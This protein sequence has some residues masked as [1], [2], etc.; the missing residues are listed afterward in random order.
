MTIVYSAN[1]EV[2]LRAPSPNMIQK[3]A[4][5][6][7]AD[8]YQ[9]VDLS[10]IDFR[11]SWITGKPKLIPVQ[12]SGSGNPSPFLDDEGVFCDDVPASSFL[13]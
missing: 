4:S 8:W 12:K 9:E 5:R 6:K 2:Q 1:V 11:N 10:G 3:R 7:L 13:P